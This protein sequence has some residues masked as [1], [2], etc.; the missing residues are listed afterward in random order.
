MT[1]LS[2]VLAAALV[3]APPPTLT[4]SEMATFLQKASVVRSRTASKGITSPLR[5]TLSDGRLTHDAA[6]QRVDEYKPVQDFGNGRREY[7]FVDSWRYNLA[8]FEI[9]E[10]IGIGEM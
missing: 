9:A 8:A 1:W 7:N 2:V 5:L 4:R 6:F 3:Q 10:L